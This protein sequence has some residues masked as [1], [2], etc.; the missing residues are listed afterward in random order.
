MAIIAKQ[1]LE[2]NPSP[3]LGTVE[4]FYQQRGGAFS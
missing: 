2:N 3:P 1:N 4:F